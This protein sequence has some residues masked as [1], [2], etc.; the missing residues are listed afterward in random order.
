[1]KDIDKENFNLKVYR[2]NAL[3]ILKDCLESVMDFV[4]NSSKTDN[5]FIDTQSDYFTNKPSSYRQK[6]LKEQGILNLLS[7]IVH[8]CFPNQIILNKVKLN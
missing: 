7:Q 8:S 1:M 6:I 4:Y 3:E 2:K 5:N